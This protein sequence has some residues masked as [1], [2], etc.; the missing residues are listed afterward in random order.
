MNDPDM[1][2]YSS[3]VFELALFQGNFWYILAAGSE[4]LRWVEMF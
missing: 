3:K 2:T 4:H 1:M